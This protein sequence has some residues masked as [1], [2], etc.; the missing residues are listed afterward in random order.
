MEMDRI[1]QMKI[2]YVSHLN[3]KSKT[4]QNKMSILK[5]KP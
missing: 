1:N 4:F 2:L 5:Q 3:V